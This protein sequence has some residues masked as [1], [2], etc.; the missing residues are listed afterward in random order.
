[1]SNATILLVDDNVTNL[2]IL[3]GCLQESAFETLI[4]QSG[5]SAL[6][7]VKYARP[8]LILLDVMMPGIDGFDTCRRLKEESSTRDIPVI[9]MSAMT[10]VVDKVAGFE[11][12]GVDYITKPFQHED[13]LARV[14]THLT[15][16]SLQQQLQEQNLLLE[17]KNQ[18]LKE[19]NAGKDKFFSIIAHDLKS[20]FAALLGLTRAITEDGIE[21]SQEE[22][23][24]V[25]RHLQSSTENLYTLLE[26]LLSWARL[27]SGKLEFRPWHVK[28]VKPVS[29]NLALFY[30]NAQ[31]KKIELKSTVAEKLSVYAD[32]NMIDTVFRN[33]VSNALKFTHSGG[34]I[35][36]SAE[37]KGDFVEVAV[38]DSGT[39]IP[40][41]DLPKLF[42]IDVKYKNSGT[43]GEEGTGLGLILCK[44][45]VEKHGGVIRVE[46]EVGKGTVFKF[47]LPA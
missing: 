46:S 5:E 11:A 12:G 33:L 32:K 17:E 25:M 38:A 9:F 43:A 41:E 42:R 20:P 21:F 27:Q 18:Q 16:R 45:L 39:G 40:E 29:Q 7:Q 30:L 37:Q 3:L 44:D 2:Q 35:A 8:D 15:I 23:R 34:R 47:T 4:A 22:I 1:M 6:R 24:E 26:N 36:I 14:K 13:V 10:D 28:L 19:V 31:Q